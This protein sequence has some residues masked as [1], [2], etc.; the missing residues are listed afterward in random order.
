MGMAQFYFHRLFYA[1]LICR[2][3][4]TKFLLQ[5][6]SAYA[7]AFD[8]LLDAYQQIGESLPLLSQYQTLFVRNPHM[9]KVLGMMYSDILE[10][11]KKALK[12]FQQ[13]SSFSASMSNYPS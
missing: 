12:Y 11:H 13:R 1:L 4:P 2:Q 10:F 7:E 9:R 5:V 8:A 3:G 6:A